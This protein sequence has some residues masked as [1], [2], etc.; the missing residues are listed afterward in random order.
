[1]KIYR[2]LTEADAGEYQNHLLRLDHD[3]RWARFNCNASDMIIGRYV[4]SIAWDACDIIGFFS[5]DYMRVAVEIRREA[6][7]HA[8]MAEIAFTVEREYQNCRVGT[9][10]MIQSLITLHER[11]ILQASVVC[12]LSNRRMQKLALKY[13]SDVVADS[14]EVFITIDINSAVSDSRLT[15]MLNNECMNIHD[16]R[17]YLIN[18]GMAHYSLELHEHS[19]SHAVKLP[20]EI[21]YVSTQES[22]DDKQSHLLIP[23]LDLGSIYGVRGRYKKYGR[24][25]AAAWLR[26]QYKGVSNA[27]ASNMV[28]KIVTAQN[29]T[30]LFSRNTNIGVHD[31]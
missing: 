25:V 22:E 14:G 8:L 19:F 28:D 3:S 26:S 10:L 15:E 20:T 13:R 1:M 31:R 24:G 5:D 12:L 21:V 16:I 11:R 2:F 4:A 30:S 6:S 9:N 18:S 29:T 17:S 7:S 23:T 27:V